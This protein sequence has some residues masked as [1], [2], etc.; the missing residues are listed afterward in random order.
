MKDPLAQDLLWD[1][2]QRR[3][4]EDAEFSDDLELALKAKGF[5][6]LA[7]AYEKQGAALAEYRA[8]LLEQ[9][10][11]ETA[12]QRIATAAGVEDADCFG[13]ILQRVEA[14][15]RGVLGSHR[16]VTDGGVDYLCSDCGADIED[17]LTD[18]LV[19]PGART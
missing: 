11:Q 8:E 4:E 13:A 5:D 17:A 18:G 6:P 9:A 2:A 19:C 10:D 1:Y 14:L 7:R 15:H 12:M 3:R 16:V